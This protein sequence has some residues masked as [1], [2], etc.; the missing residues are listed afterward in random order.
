MLL[1]KVLNLTPTMIKLLIKVR[2]VT[3]ELNNH[4]QSVLDN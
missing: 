4:P 1:I 3:F 2:Q